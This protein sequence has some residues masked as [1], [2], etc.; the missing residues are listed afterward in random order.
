MCQFSETE[1]RVFSEES[2]Q[3]ALEDFPALKL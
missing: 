2:I 3:A 1:G